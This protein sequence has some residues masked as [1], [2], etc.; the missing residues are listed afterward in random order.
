M[1]FVW[2]GNLEAGELERFVSLEFYLIGYTIGNNI[3]PFLGTLTL[4]VS[5]IIGFCGIFLLPL[6]QMAVGMLVCEIL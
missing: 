5:D 4:N 2:L 6:R 1:T 3:L